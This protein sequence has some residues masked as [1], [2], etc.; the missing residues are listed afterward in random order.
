AVRRAV[1]IS[2]IVVAEG[3]AN[4]EPIEN[5]RVADYHSRGVDEAYADGRAIDVDRREQHAPERNG[6]VPVAG[7][8][9]EAARRPDEMRRHPNV[10]RL[11][12]RP[13][14]GAPGVAIAFPDPVAGDV[15]RVG[16]RWN[17]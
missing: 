12:L 1:G 11:N 2:E 10:S 8:K 14:S 4:G 13:V 3:G 15:K 17:A 5:N 9:N 7:D 16:G 6:Q